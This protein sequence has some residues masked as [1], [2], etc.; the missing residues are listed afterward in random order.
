MDPFSIEMPGRILFG[1]G[2]AAQAPDLIRAFGDRG[3]IVHGA[4]FARSDWLA[5]ALDGCALMRWP[6][7]G[8]PTLPDLQ[9]A[10]GYA[11]AFDPLWI[12]GVGGGAAMDLGK[13]LAALI[14][15]AGDPLDH[16]EVVGRAR[17]LHA[18]PLPFVAIP[19]TAGTGAEVTKNA[20]IGLPDH[21]RKVSLRDHRMLARLAVV[22]PA[23]T[24]DC[25][26]AVTLA[27]GLDAVA[28]VIEPF[29]SCRATPYTDALTRGAMAPG[30]AALVQLV[31]GPQDPADERRRAA[32]DAMAW[33]SLSGGL[34]LA[35]G[36]LGAVHGLAGVIGGR[37]GAAHGAICG[38]L[39]GPA[40]NVNRD[41]AT[42]PAR[43]RIDAA[44]A[45]IASVLG[46]SADDAPARLSD[47]ARGAGLPSL[48]DMGVGRAD[49]AAV[50]EAAAAASSTRGNPV[51]LATADLARILDMAG[52]GE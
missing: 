48:R 39:L 11:R 50:A 21:G 43:A 3:V 17:P 7:R 5:E 23:L 1:R 38:L 37:T 52:A 9:E 19:T 27:S 47:W 36:G 31:D 12:A 40:L 10:L 6:S 30:L 8:E 51:P 44:C 46:G 32:R 34:A 25:P 20:V 28:Q 29:V 22:D 42:G 24:D 2:V 33:C 16:L 4:S 45:A 18:P 15:A 35:N 14:P 41:R 49:I 26:R 13:A